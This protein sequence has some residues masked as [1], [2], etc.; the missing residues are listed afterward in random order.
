MYAIE[1]LQHNSTYVTGTSLAMIDV[2]HALKQSI[3][4]PTYPMPYPN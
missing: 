3:P 1:V 2:E 4:I